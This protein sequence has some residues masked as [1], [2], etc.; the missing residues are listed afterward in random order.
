[1][2]KTHRSNVR[3]R[4]G[5][6]RVRITLRSILIGIVLSVILNFVAVRNYIVY[7]AY[8]GFADHFNTVGVVW[9]LFI[10]SLLNFLLR[11]SMPKFCMSPVELVVVYAMLMVATAYPTM[12]FGGYL[13]PLIGGVLYYAKPENRWDELLLP[14]LPKHLIPQDKFAVRW[15][16]EGGVSS[17]PISVWIAPLVWWTAFAVAWFILSVCI[18]AV[19]RKQWVEREKLVYPLAQVP[20]HLALLTKEGHS[21]SFY[22]SGLMW[23]GFA[24]S[25]WLSTHNY[26]AQ[27]IPT[28]PPLKLTNIVQLQRLGISFNFGIDTL[29]IG[30]TYLI[31]LDVAFSVWLFHLLTSFE[32]GL[33][34]FIGWSVIGPPQP[35]AAGG[36]LLSAQQFGAML[37]LIIW[38]LKVALREAKVVLHNATH[39]EMPSL[40]KSTTQTTL[41]WA[42]KLVS[43]KQTSNLA[44]NVLMLFSFLFILFFLALSGIPMWAILPFVAIAM[45]LFYGTTRL[46]VQTGIGRLRAPCA[47]AP[48]LIDLFGTSPF[49][50]VGLAALG[51]TFVWAGDIQLFVMGTAAHAFKLAG[52]AGIS[53][54]INFAVM[55]SACILSILTTLWSYLSLGYRHGLINGYVWYF[56][57]S[58]NYH[59]GWIADCIQNPRPPQWRRVSFMVGGMACGS[60]L[61]A[62]HSRV[63]NFPFHPIGLC[64][65][66][67]NTV[68]WDWF[69]MAVA[70]AAKLFILRYGGLSAYTTSLP[71][72]WGMILGST[73]GRSIV[74]LTA[75]R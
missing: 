54:G 64:I 65:S 42:S 40:N 57:S 59:W 69:S 61:I 47:A 70:W 46:L 14:N 72:F 7:N 22:R 18:V 12:G 71:F 8:S 16:F 74:A 11:S 36:P 29:V 19:F 3:D 60:A 33:L 66:Q 4:C 67:I 63:A 31:N 49:G 1:M 50:P 24:I 5:T 13:I 6:V 43:L 44:V 21:G 17:P 2:D 23:L 58:P 9:L 48:L 39:I 26:L 73:V 20:A 52:D 15:L 37:A 55:L 35:H 68:F 32:L 34:N 30:L 10:L 75:R 62:L 25:F 51:L 27:R 38:S 45:T 41:E 28:L 53:F 56:V